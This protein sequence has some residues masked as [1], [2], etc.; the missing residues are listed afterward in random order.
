[1]TKVLPGVSGFLFLDNDTNNVQLQTSGATVLTCERMSLIAAAH[2]SASARAARSGAKYIHVVAPNKET[3]Y[4]G[5]L[6]D[7]AAYE[8]YGETPVRGYLKALPEAR[9]HTFFDHDAL[10]PSSSPLPNYDRQD[11]HWTA[12]G[13]AHYLKRAFQYFWRPRELSS[14][15]LLP[16]IAE[17]VAVAGDLAIIAGIAPEVVPKL[18]LAAPQHSISFYGDVANEGYIQHATCAAGTG[19]LLILH[20][21]FAYQPL[22]FL[23]EIFAETLS[24]H[25]PDF[26]IDLEEA[27]EPDLIIKIQ[28]ERFFPYVP[29]DRISTLDWVEEVERRKGADCSRTR[30]FLSSF[31]PQRLAEAAE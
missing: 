7:P 4:R 17:K 1:M 22:E 6:P 28:A 5:F 31:L 30:K 15:E 19:R 11:S 13:G 25:C 3:A 9:T 26:L 29:V 23:S 21:S 16:T 12:S 8:Q 27:Y 20:D 2:V 14:F 18:K 10:L 24:L